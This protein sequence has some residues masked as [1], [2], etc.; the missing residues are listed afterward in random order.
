MK[1]SVKII[2]PIIIVILMGLFYISETLDY[3]EKKYVMCR[4]HFNASTKICNTMFLE[5][6]MI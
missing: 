5:T 1:N 4:E 2:I 6:I 3:N